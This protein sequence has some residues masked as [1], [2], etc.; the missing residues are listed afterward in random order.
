M[1]NP[2]AAHGFYA[3]SDSQKTAFPSSRQQAR[4]LATLEQASPIEIASWFESPNSY[5]DDG[6]PRDLLASEPELVFG[7][8]A[9]SLVAATH[10]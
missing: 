4:I 3:L 1:D 10:G 6:R 2:C 9:D 7:A 5:L 8:A